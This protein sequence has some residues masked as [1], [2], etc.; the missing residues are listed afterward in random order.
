M[1][2]RRHREGAVEALLA[3]GV[4][5]LASAFQAFPDQAGADF[6]QF[7]G[8]P[9]AKKISGTSQTPYVDA[10]GYAGALNAF[11]DRSGQRQAARGK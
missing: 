11:S 6:Y 9:V 10:A 8:V 4:Y 3:A 7:W 2:P 5:L 1:L